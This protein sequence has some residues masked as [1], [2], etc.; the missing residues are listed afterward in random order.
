M[1]QLR[2]TL[3]NSLNKRYQVRLKKSKL[4]YRNLVNE[5]VMQL[6][7]NHRN[8]ESHSNLKSHLNYAFLRIEKGL[9]I[10]GLIL[11]SM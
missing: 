1:K 8:L 6:I 11:V 2:S 10:P 3:I 5:I 7:A 4:K 9:A